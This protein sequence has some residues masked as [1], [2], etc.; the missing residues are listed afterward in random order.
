MRNQIR[1]ILYLLLGLSLILLGIAGLVL[2]IIN[3]TILL[4]IGFIIISFES[5]T[6]EKKLY[7]LTQKNAII[8]GLYVKIDR[9]LRKFFKK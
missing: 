9:F 3:G 6:L 1:K 7:T 8:H 5:P 2:P 4:I